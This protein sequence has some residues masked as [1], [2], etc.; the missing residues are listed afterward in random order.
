MSYNFGKGPNEMPNL[1]WIDGWGITVTE[2]LFGT[3]KLESGKKEDEI[4]QKS[5]TNEETHHTYWS[6]TGKLT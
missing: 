1:R 5:Y 4:T 3:K 6:S 2:N